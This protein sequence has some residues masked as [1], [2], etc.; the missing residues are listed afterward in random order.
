MD[1]PFHWDTKAVCNHFC[2]TGVKWT[3]DPAGLQSRIRHHELDG[4][5]LLGFEFTLSNAELMEYLGLAVAKHKMQFVLEIKRLRARSPAFAD[6]KQYQLPPDTFTQ[7][8]SSTPQSPKRSLASAQDSDL[9]KSKKEPIQATHPEKKRRKV[10][11]SFIGVTGSVPSQFQQEARLDDPVNGGQ[12][13]F[14]FVSG[15]NASVAQRSNAYIQMRKYMRNV[16]RTEMKL[17]QGEV[18]RAVS[19]SATDD[20]VLDL[21]DLD[22]GV[23]EQTRREMEMDAQS[24]NEEEL[25]RPPAFVT[26]ERVREILEEQV[27]EMKRE[28]NRTKKDK[29]ERRAYKLWTSTKTPSARKEACARIRAKL[30]GHDKQRKKVFEGIAS[31]QWS[32]EE[33][34]IEQTTSLAQPVFEI[35]YSQLELVTMMGSKP[36][37]QPSQPAPSVQPKP[38]ERRRGRS[39]SLD[40]SDDEF[41]VSD[42][43]EPAPSTP[44][45]ERRDVQIRLK[46]PATRNRNN[47]IDLTLTTPE[48]PD[49]NELVRGTPGEIVDLTCQVDPGTT[50]SFNDA[51]IISTIGLKSHK[52]FEADKDRFKLVISL[53]WKLAHRQQ[54]EIF[55]IAKDPNS[56]DTWKSTVQCFLDARLKGGNKRP[57]NGNE[58]L[59]IA[60][61]A[62]F[63]SFWKCKAYTSERMTNI[64]TKKLQK[65]VNRVKDAQKT[66]FPQFCHFLT[67]ISPHFPSEDRIFRHED[68][69]TSDTERNVESTSKTKK[70]KKVYKEIVEDRHAKQMRDRD[71]QKAK[72]REVN[73]ARLKAELL[74]DGISMSDPSKVIINTS[75]TEDQSLIFLN[76]DIAKKIKPH[77]IDGVRF[78]WERIVVDPKERQGCLLSHTMGLGKTMQTITLLIAIRECANS[79][80]PA[81]KSQIPQD[82]LPQRT[83]ILC[84]AG[85]VNNWVAEIRQWDTHSVLQSIT[86]VDSELSVSYRHSS[87]VQWHYRG[88]VLVMGY[89]MFAG[90]LKQHDLR[91]RDV[92]LQG[93][94]MVIA[95]EAH[96]LKNRESQIASECAKF[97]TPSRIALTGSPMANN[98]EEYYSMIEWLA[99]GYLGPINEFSEIFVKRIQEGLYSDSDMS[100]KRL[101]LQLLQTLKLRVAPKVN[102]A[103]IHALKDDLPE[104]VEFVISVM[105]TEVQKELYNTYIEGLQA[106]NGGKDHLG[107][108]KV[109]GVMTHLDLIC[110]HPECFRTKT[111]EIQ[112][113]DTQGDNGDDSDQITKGGD[114]RDYAKS[115]PKIIIPKVLAQTKQ[116]DMNDFKLSRKVEILCLILDEAKMVEDKVL[117]FSQSLTTLDYL[118]HLFERQNREYCR[119][120][121][122]TPT[123]KRQQDVSKFNSGST[124]VYL[125]STTAGGV[126]LNIQSANRVVIFDQKWNPVHDQQAIGRAYRMGQKKRVVVYRFIT[127]GTFEEDIQNKSIFK[128]QLAARIVDKKSPI[129]WS[130]RHGN[131]VHPLYSTT[132]VALESF[133]GSDRTLDKMILL[134]K[135]RPM[136]QSIVS[137]DTFEEEDPTDNLTADERQTAERMVIEDRQRVSNPGG[138]SKHNHQYVMGQG[139][140]TTQALL[141][142][143]CASTAVLS[144]NEGEEPVAPAA[145]APG[146]I[147]DWMLNFPGAS[148]LKAN[149]AP[150]P[151][152]GANTFFEN[153]A[154]SPRSLSKN[155]ATYLPA[156]STQT[157]PGL[158][159]QPKPVID[160]ASEQSPKRNRIAFEAPRVTIKDTFEKTLSDRF[161]EI[162]GELIGKDAFSGQQAARSITKAVAH[163]RERETLGF[164]YDNNQWAM[165][166]RVVNGEPRLALALAKGSVSPSDLALISE[167]ELKEKVTGLNDVEE[168]SFDREFAVGMKK[169]HDEVRSEC[170][171][172]GT[173]MDLTADDLNR[174]RGT[175]NHKR[176]IQQRQSLGSRSF[177]R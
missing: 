123:T 79:L 36:P 38:K 32:S 95:D 19:E 158:D 159:V 167:A 35:M 69:I 168:T 175:R 55:N 160:L 153:E 39:I 170:C 7:R 43:V 161:R 66:F 30:A 110:S 113:F 119:L 54:Q 149:P 77:Q 68:L 117:V 140:L 63:W 78:L 12:D 21:A 91:L 157:A 104:K 127:A 103:T 5:T 136:I 72:D 9:L 101:A 121:G 42:A 14:S 89:E 97:G 70:A 31:E 131:I 45:R 26:E 125:I 120:D 6:W 13:D 34:I 92:L 94:N 41:I 2:V 27:C 8:P 154:D 152:A 84:P 51:D 148:R 75:K 80:N 124:Q 176:R 96:K 155:H 111:L 141:T 47:F 133:V 71:I 46:T 122:S 143:A 108:A 174:K 107:Q 150:M 156:H 109:F 23:D 3:N 162:D 86:K 10:A 49:K 144:L 134:N 37:A 99:P 57:A 93:P 169:S 20:D 29:A 165:L 172:W 164:L 4:E 126:G 52:T 22:E 48:Q 60:F 138:V 1:D 142:G 100:S 33:A 61:T 65:D 139:D 50:D 98:V 64:K 82:L 87:I 106:S 90:L 11:P 173:S 53:L 17:Q 116:V 44:Q 145:S 16:T 28:W 129:R 25:N 24:E 83:L 171:N 76:T 128:M 105:P 59:S 135:I 132:P 18:E 56:L 177:E 163:I 88:G 112:K 58:K 114:E 130:K 102:R 115:Y 74:R 166:T 40:S 146:K 151:I 67:E 81:I 62:I 85:L 137:A 15:Q 147:P 118:Q 73:A